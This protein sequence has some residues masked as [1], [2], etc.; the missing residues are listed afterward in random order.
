MDEVV[1]LIERQPSIHAR[2]RQRS[3]QERPAASAWSLASLSLSRLGLTIPFPSRRC[4]SCPS[5][6]ERAV[7]RVNT[8][9][10]RHRAVSQMSQAILPLGRHALVLGA[11]EE[12]GTQGSW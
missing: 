4:P 11:R 9:D 6:P 12:A 7:T 1:M 2:P 3:V 5:V 10:T 8:W